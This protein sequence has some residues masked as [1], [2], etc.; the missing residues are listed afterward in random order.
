VFRL[1]AIGGFSLCKMYVIKPQL[2][3]RPRRLK[4]P[5]KGPWWQASHMASDC[6]KAAPVVFRYPTVLF[7]GRKLFFAYFAAVPSRPLRL[8][9][10]S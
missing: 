3:A 9:A 6:I 8:N 7:F 4:V 5:T 2:D 10:F 1:S